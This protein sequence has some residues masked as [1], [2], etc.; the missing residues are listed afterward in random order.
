MKEFA[1]KILLYRTRLL[2]IPFLLH[3]AFLTNLI[4]NMMANFHGYNIYDSCSGIH[5]QNG[6]HFQQREVITS[7]NIETVSSVFQLN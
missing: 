5:K 1:A 4:F 7:T 2:K 6:T 3:C